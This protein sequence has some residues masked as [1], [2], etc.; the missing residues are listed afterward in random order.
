MGS[1]DYTATPPDHPSPYSYDDLPPGKTDPSLAHFS[2]AHDQSYIL[3]LL[4]QVKRINPQ[5]TT[6]AAP[7]SPPAWMKTNGSMVNGSVRDDSYGVLAQYFV[8][9]LQLYHSAGVPVDAITPQ[10]EPDEINHGF[11]SVEMSASQEASLI[12]HYLGPALAE[13]GL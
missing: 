13:A 5:I 8:H 10:N 3:P 6:I 11:P 12:A 2:I 1:S 7:W 9:F 4:L